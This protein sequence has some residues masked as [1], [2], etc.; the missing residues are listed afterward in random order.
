[1]REQELAHRREA[2]VV[3]QVRRAL[4]ECV[5]FAQPLAE[6]EKAAALDAAVGDIGAEVVK[7]LRLAVCGREGDLDPA[8]HPLDRLAVGR[9]DRS[10]GI[11][12]DEL[13]AGDGFPGPRQERVEDRQGAVEL[14]VAQLRPHL[15]GEEEAD[16][17]HASRRGAQMPEHAWQRAAGDVL[18]LGDAPDRLE[19]AH[20][21]GGR[22]RE[23][24]VRVEEV[25]TA[26]HVERGRLPHRQVLARPLPDARE[27]AAFEPLPRIVEVARMLLP[28][29]L[30]GERCQRRV[31]G[32]LQPGQ[33][34]RH[35]VGRRR[36]GG[37]RRARRDQQRHDDGDHGGPSQLQHSDHLPSRSCPATREPAGTESHSATS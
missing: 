11:D 31:G 12:L 10:V 14:G 33:E 26:E 35:V 30:A 36:V 37:A 5:A 8:R 19:P 18:H 6:L 16:P 9:F 1:M 21:V 29:P 34:P 27:L 13:D 32:G 24:G 15:V 4:N 3:H 23:K 2:V 20:H 22:A 7:R 28:G 17:Q 25:G